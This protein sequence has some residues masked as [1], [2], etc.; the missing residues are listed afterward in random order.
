MKKFL[1]TFAAL[2][3]TAC[4]VF[5]QQPRVV[6]VKPGFATVIVCPSPPEL[7][8]VGSPDQFSAQNAG[9]YILVKPVVS[10]G[11]TNMFIKAGTDSYNI[12][13]Q[14]SDSPDLE[15]RLPG[16][17]PTPTNPIATHRNG[18]PAKPGAESSPTTGA[19]A[20][21][22]SAPVLTT[23]AKAILSSY[24]KT[25]RPY[26]Y[27]VVNSDVVL[28]VDHM[29]MIEDKLYIICTLVNNSSIRYDIGYIRFKLVDHSR[30]YLFFKKQ[31]KEEELEPSHEVYASI[32]EP[33]NSTRLLFV[34]EKHG[35]SSKSE[36]E[37]K[38]TEE[39]GRRDLSL[40][41][42]GSFVE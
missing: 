3:L 25:P 24:M 9:K 14:V 32:V 38:C 33:N 19:P 36:I 42:P 10:R 8:S 12:L 21:P 22:K 6:K 4:L 7:V 41:V 1:T 20:Q 17:Q 18:K 26:T 31:I 13:L 11:S 2:G 5:A 34:F 28:A 16:S 29:A 15:V 40:R 39:S 30:S 27:S 23:K 37:I 35:F